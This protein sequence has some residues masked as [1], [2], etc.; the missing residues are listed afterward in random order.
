MVDEVYDFRPSCEKLLALPHKPADRPDLITLK[1][2]RSLRA[3][4]PDHTPAFWNPSRL[5][6]HS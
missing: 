2:P 1:A 6:C 4:E 3:F 5:G